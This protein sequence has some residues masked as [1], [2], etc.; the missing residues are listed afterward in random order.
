MTVWKAMGVGLA[1]TATLA[2]T[3]VIPF[4]VYQLTSNPDYAVFAVLSYMLFVGS[5]GIAY[6]DGE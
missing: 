2:M 4:V 6:F 5:S 3:V 1:V